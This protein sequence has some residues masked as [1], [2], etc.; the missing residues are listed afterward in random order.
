MTAST[1]KWEYL[2]VCRIMLGLLEDCASE[3]KE[4]LVNLTK[5]NVK[6]RIN[7]IESI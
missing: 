3:I 6:V 1:G 5:M 2:F 4:N 7:L